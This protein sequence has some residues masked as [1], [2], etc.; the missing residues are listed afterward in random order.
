MQSNRSLSR[1]LALLSL[2]LIKDQGDMKFNNL[3]VEEIFESAIDSLIMNQMPDFRIDDF[4]GDPDEDLTDT[5]EDLMELRR[6]L[7]DDPGVRVDV[8]ANLRAVEDLL[9][10][11]V[12]ETL[13][14]LT[15][16]KTNFEMFYDIK[17]DTIKTYFTSFNKKAS[18]KSLKL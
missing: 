16:A 12:K 15:P 6:K 11:E 7:L 1:E 9:T 14:I 10:D 18:T 13:E 3:Q 2:G 8:E 4:I 17:N 5:Y